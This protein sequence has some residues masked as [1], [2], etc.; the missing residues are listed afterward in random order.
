MPILHIEH[1]VGDFDTWKRNAFDAD[2]I[3]RARSGV[4]RHRI[5][6]STDD[7]NFVMIELEFNTKP[8]AEVMHAALRNLWRNP[9]AQIGGPTARIIE[10]VEAKEY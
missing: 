10:T 7:P 1:Q 6:R 3:G 9:L 8:E 4:R 5:S 2:P